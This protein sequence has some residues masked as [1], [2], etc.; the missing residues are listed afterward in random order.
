[1]GTEL[2]EKGLRVRRGVLG[3]Q[4]VDSSISADD[5]QRPLQ[6]M[7]TECCWGAVWTPPKRG[8]RSQTLS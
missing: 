1:M 6:D 4:Y 8:L 2:F 5:F 7:V 3:A